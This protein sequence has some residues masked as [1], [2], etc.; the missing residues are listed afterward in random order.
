MQKIRIGIVGYG[1]LGKGAE[2]GI[3]QNKD[4][5]LVAVFTR[6]NPDSIQLKTNDAKVYSINEITFMTKEIDVMLLCGGSLTDIPVQGPEIAALFNTV[7]GFDTH[8]KIPDYYATM[9]E[10]AKKSKKVSI[11]ATG[12]DPGMFS[13]NRLIANSILPEGDTYTF[14]GEGISQGHSDAL[15]RVEGVQ[16]GLQY[17][18]PIS[19]AV[20][21]VRSGKRPKL[22]VKD[23]HKR[24]CYVVL[25]D[26]YSEKKIEQEIINMPNYFA[27]YDTKVEFISQE[28]LNENHKGLPHGGYVI[29]SGV[30]GI[31]NEHNQIIEYKIKLDSN[32]EFTANILLAYVRAAYRLNKEG[33][34]G[35]KTLFDIAPGYLSILSPEDL[36]RSLL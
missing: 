22:S 8:K 28:E 16:D 29:R 17:T 20:D 3:M 15:R 30:T 35:A 31:N 32:P 18:I 2:L 12:W 19:E 25:K 24:I 11:I 23:R 36:R 21:E 27:E 4:M 6:R 34:T 5:E 7:D 26:G 9:D 13:L 14:W 10:I 33:Q 1:N